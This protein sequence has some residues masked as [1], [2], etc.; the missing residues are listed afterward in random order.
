MM[1][2]TVLMKET[3]KRRK[4]MACMMRFFRECC[5]VKHMRSIRRAVA[6]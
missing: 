2:I 1:K 3:I 5:W 4:M 6:R